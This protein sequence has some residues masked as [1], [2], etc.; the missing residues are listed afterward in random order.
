VALARVRTILESL[1]G[2]RRDGGPPR[3]V[4]SSSGSDAWDD[5]AATTIVAMTEHAARALGPTCSGHAFAAAHRALK[6]LE[7]DQVPAAL[8]SGAGSIGAAGAAPPAGADLDTA[9]FLDELGGD[10]AT[11]ARSASRPRWR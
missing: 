5:A 11:A 4:V 6:R 3:Q 2:G 1:D 8:A 10:D 9:R 7:D